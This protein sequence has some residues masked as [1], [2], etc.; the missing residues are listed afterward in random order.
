MSITPFRYDTWFWV[1][2]VHNDRLEFVLAEADARKG[3]DRCGAHV[4]TTYTQA[5]YEMLESEFA[6]ETEIRIEESCEYGA[7][8]F[9]FSVTSLDLMGPALARC[10]K[11]VN[12]WINKYRIN[13]M[14]YRNIS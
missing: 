12:K 3:E 4:R 7:L 9:S 10:E 1:N 11:V 13:K 6:K 5:L 2:T 8:S 14:Q